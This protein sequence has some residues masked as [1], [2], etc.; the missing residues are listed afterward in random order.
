[1]L[2][3]F[4][5][6][7]QQVTAYLTGNTHTDAALAVIFL[8]RIEIFSLN[9][10]QVGGIK[11]AGRTADHHVVLTADGAVGLVGKPEGRKLL[12]GMQHAACLLIG[13]IH[14]VGKSI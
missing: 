2:V 9:G 6:F 10:R 14:P 5:E 12:V 7:Q 8:H 4:P 3:F 11:T 1:M 13:A